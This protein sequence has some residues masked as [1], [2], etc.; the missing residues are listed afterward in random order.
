[1]GTPEVGSHAAEQRFRQV[2]SE[3]ATL[4]QSVADLGGAVPGDPNAPLPDVLRNAETLIIG[5]TQV[6][7]S[8]E[9]DIVPVEFQLRDESG[10]PVGASHA[11]IACWSPGS[12]PAGWYYFRRDRIEEILNGPSNWPGRGT[13]LPDTPP[14]MGP[15]D[16]WAG[17]VGHW[18][19]AVEGTFAYSEI[20]L[21]GAGAEPF[22]MAEDLP[23]TWAGFGARAD[24]IVG[25]CVGGSI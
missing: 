19:G 24:D 11:G 3:V 8:E 6:L 9:A 12:T 18:M 13:G 15:C 7:T 23:T 17:L 4:T 16:E 22:F 1:M 5:Y 14:P 25:V 10:N 21:S 2:E 20:D